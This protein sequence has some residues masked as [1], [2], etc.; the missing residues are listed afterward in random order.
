M[1]RQLQSFSDAGVYFAMSRL[2]KSIE[3]YKE[4]EKVKKEEKEET[5]AGMANVNRM[6]PFPP[7]AGWMCGEK[8][9]KSRRRKSR[10]FFV[11]GKSVFGAARMG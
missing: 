7:L 4:K 9:G 3:E 2:S 1:P 5:T 8:S 10:Y 6:L 11:R